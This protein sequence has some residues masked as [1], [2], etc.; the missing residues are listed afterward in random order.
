MLPQQLSGPFGHLQTLPLGVGID[1]LLVD[2][3]VLPPL[4]HQFLSGLF[5]HFKVL[6]DHFSDVTL[7]GG[8]FP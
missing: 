6:L 2:Y 8:A 7:L 1:H 3:V 4:M 5:L